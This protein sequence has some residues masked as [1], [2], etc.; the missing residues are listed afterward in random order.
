MRR[1]GYFCWSFPE[2]YKRSKKG[3]IQDEIGIRN[4]PPIPPQKKK[5]NDD[6]AE[7]PALL[8]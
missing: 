6:T 4:P 7:S 5:K 1:T 3:D 2:N 8:K